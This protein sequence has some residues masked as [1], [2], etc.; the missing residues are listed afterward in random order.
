MLMNEDQIQVVVLDM[1]DTLLR[2]D[3]SMSDRT[4][5]ALMRWRAGGGQVVIATGRPPRA[6]A[7]SLPKALHDVPF[8]CYNGADA[9]QAGQVLHADLIAPADVQHVLA[10]AEHVSDDYT[11]G[12]EIDDC[13]YLNRPPDRFKNFVLTEDL[14]AVATQPAAKILF[15][16]VSRELDINQ[17][18]MLLETVVA[19][20]PPSIRPM[21]STRYRLLQLMSHTADKVEALQ[22]VLA[23]LGLTLDHAVAF[24]DDVNDV[25]MVE[26]SG[27]GVAV[28]NAVPEVHAVADRMTHS[29]DEDGVAAVIE[30]LLS[31][32]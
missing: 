3:G 5:D 4:L 7:G 26:Q 25:G 6:V 8:I 10:A 19:D 11:I 30:E 2:S 9:R 15:V 1:D 21:H 17:D 29:N 23:Q 32:R 22:I 31:N 20:L 28:A 24:G 18:T 16:P 14:L 12:L 27:L 13:L